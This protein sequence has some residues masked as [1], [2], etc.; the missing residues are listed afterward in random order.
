MYSYICIEV[1]YKVVYYTGRMLNKRKVLTSL[2]L[3]DCSI[4]PED[5]SDVCNAVGIMTKLTSLNLSKN[6]LCDQSTAS[7]GKGLIFFTILFSY[8][9]CTLTEL[10]L[11]HHVA[12]NRLLSNR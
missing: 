2:Q 7:V 8:D 12:V 3:K 4:G 6:M 10:W 11:R 5:L 9:R 1:G